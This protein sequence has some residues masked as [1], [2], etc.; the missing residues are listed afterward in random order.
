MNLSYLRPYI[1]SY[2][3]IRPNKN[4]TADG[5]GALKDSALAKE[6]L[7]TAARGERIVSLVYDHW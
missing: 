3:Y 2:R 6:L 4:S 1:S 7:V 5:G